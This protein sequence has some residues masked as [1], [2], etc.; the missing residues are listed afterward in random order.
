MQAIGLR[1]AVRKAVNPA[2]GHT[3]DRVAERMD[4]TSNDWR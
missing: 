2:R 4:S 3:I 1:E